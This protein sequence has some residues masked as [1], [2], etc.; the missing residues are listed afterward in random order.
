V[1]Q[2]LEEV[3]ESQPQGNI[4]LKGRAAMGS[5]IGLF[6]VYTNGNAL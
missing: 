4:H 6:L 2:A 3:L 1:S 5:M